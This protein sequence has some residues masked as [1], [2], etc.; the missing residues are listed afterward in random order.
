[1]VFQY[2]NGSQGGGGCRKCQEKQGGG[3]SPWQ[4][5]LNLRAVHC[6]QCDPTQHRA[7]DAKIGQLATT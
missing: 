4:K 1:M 5:T 7:V 6:F 3:D 2:F